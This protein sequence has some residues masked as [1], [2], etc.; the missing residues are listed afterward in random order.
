M[1]SSMIS[2][3]RNSTDFS[4]AGHFIGFISIKVNFR[5]SACRSQIAAR[6][7][8]SSNYIDKNP[9]DEEIHNC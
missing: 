8:R 2:L 3:N 1:M 9:V 4:S 7:R 5:T 6:T